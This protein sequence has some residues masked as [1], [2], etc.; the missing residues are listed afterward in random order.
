MGVNGPEWLLRASAI[1][2]SVV[3]R[4]CSA[5]RR[6]GQEYSR[7]EGILSD[8]PKACAPTLVNTPCLEHQVVRS[9]S[10]AAG[11]DFYKLSDLKQHTYHLTVL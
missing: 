6:A 10:I 5:S 9:F 3:L 2:P 1:E 4:R 11:T 7:Q 8:V